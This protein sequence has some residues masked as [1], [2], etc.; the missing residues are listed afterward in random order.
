MTDSTD[1]KNPCERKAKNTFAH[2]CKICIYAKFAYMQITSM[3]TGFK[4]NYVFLLVIFCVIILCINRWR[5]SFI[6]YGIVKRHSRQSNVRRIWT[7]ADNEGGSTLNLALIGQ[8]VS[9]EKV[10]EIVTNCGRATDGRRRRTDVGA[11]VYYKLT[12]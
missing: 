7:C 3:C 10:F 9:E 12:L 4:I 1:F 6:L 8:E 11:W 5:S 2:L